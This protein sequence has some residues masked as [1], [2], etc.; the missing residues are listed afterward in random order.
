MGG[1]DKREQPKEEEAS[2]TLTSSK[3]AQSANTYVN[4][5]MTK[6]F[7]MHATVK[8]QRSDIAPAVYAQIQYC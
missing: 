3:T 6:N 7:D 4:K 1:P 2:T 8:L 5:L